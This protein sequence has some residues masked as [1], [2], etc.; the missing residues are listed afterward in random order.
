MNRLLYILAL[1]GSLLIIGVMQVR[2]TDLAQNFVVEV[3]MA[4]LALSVA[5]V[6]FNLSV[7][8]R[9][10][11]T[12]YIGLAFLAAGTFELMHALLSKGIFLTP[13]ATLENFHYVGDLLDNIILSFMLACGM[14]LAVKRPG[15]WATW[16]YYSVIAVVAAS[17][18]IVALSQAPLPEMVLISGEPRYWFAGL[19]PC[20]GY[21]VFVVA[22]V[23]SS[24]SARSLRERLLGYSLLPSVLVLTMSQVILMV[25][26]FSVQD[27]T[28]I[29]QALKIFAYVLA[30]IP[31]L[32]NLWRYAAYSFQ[33]AGARLA[34]LFGITLLVLSLLTMLQFNRHEQE[35]KNSEE[36][37]LVTLLQEQHRL[38]GIEYAIQRYLLFGDEQYLTRLEK[39]WNLQKDVIE[40]LRSNE[41]SAALERLSQRFVRLQALS[42]QILSISETDEI[43][44]KIYLAEQFMEVMQKLRQYLSDVVERESAQLSQYKQQ[45]IAV[46]HDRLVLELSFLLCAILLVVFASRR[47]NWNQVRPVINLNDVA[48]KITS[49]ERDVE[50][51]SDRKDEIGKLS[52]SLDAML[53]HL[54]SAVDELESRVEE[55]TK[56]LSRSEQQLRNIMDHVE[57]GIITANHRGI[58]QSVNPAACK[59]FGFDVEQLTG[60]PIYKLMPEDQR[61][62]HIK[63]IS[64]YSDPNNLKSMGIHRRN[65][66]GLRSDGSTFSLEIGVTEV[67]KDG[68]RT[69]IAVLRDITERLKAQNA[70]KESEQRLSRF[71]DA[72]LEGLLFHE[73]GKIVDVNNAALKLFNCHLSDIIDKDLEQFMPADQREVLQ[74][75]L[76]THSPELWESVIEC[77][78][79]SRLPVE[80]QTRDVSFDCK[81]TSITVVR[82]IT[83][84][85]TAQRVLNRH[86]QFTSRILDIVGSLVF[87]VDAQ[88]NIVRFNKACEQLTGYAYEDVKG[89]PIWEV[90]PD[91]RDGSDIRQLYCT[92][93]VKDFPNQRRFEWPTKNGEIR[94]IDWINSAFISEDGMVEYVIG[95]GVDVTDRL[96][97]E[98]VLANQLQTLERKVRERTRELDAMFTLSP[99]GFVMINENRQVIYANPAF[100]DMTGFGPDQIIGIA[101]QE[102]C[103]LLTG[104]CDISGEDMAI[105]DANYFRENSTLQLIRPTERVINCAVRDM[106]DERNSTNGLV[107]YIRDITHE[108]EVDQMKS[109][110]LST[111]AHEFRTPLSSILGFSELLLTSNV[112]EEKRASVTEI[113]YRQSV[114]L[115]SL[116]DELLDLARIDARAG[117]DFYIAVDT[118]EAL[119]KETVENTKS[120]ANEKHVL[121]VELPDKWPLVAFDYDKMRQVLGNVLGNAYKYS[122]DGG[123]VTCTT[124]IR[125]QG[126]Q[127]QFGIKIQ[128]QGIG[129]TP[130]EL[131]RVGERFYRADSSGA[132]PGTGLGVS[133]VKE[134]MEIHKGEV[135]I[136]SAKDRGTTVVLWLPVISDQVTARAV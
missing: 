122:P 17:I 115:K 22:L 61:E 35:I 124:V 130:E 80:I 111:A 102:F 132:I 28:A 31:A 55:R 45:K 90:M 3:V 77:A 118:P 19:L 8:P 13:A 30:L 40:T 69:F 42:Q 133:L 91:L 63:T 68:K 67:I 75:M 5:L 25:P 64:K 125:E 56:E 72:S 89:E 62:A 84:R 1:A 20:A 39:L 24:S 50:I 131:S 83:E 15:I 34:T 95:A 86:N 88:G 10:R 100:F 101:E 60:S 81:T 44:H 51:V 9:N 12:P 49:G 32:V 120:L 18:I 126:R 94:T 54:R 110:F 41:D 99:D 117:K 36:Q 71:F 16:H 59:I 85:K 123:Q 121:K 92:P 107:L 21:F 76:G 43:S 109:E 73:R 48:N 108:T 29:A 53:R 119:I 26:V 46:I 134:I 105:K 58:I 136:S 70:L 97:V 79:G 116:L 37:L 112:K 52:K 57:E 128:D 93:D 106:E 78:D 14:R 103:R 27:A 4:S 65:E 87:V 129:M 74:R 2:P 114:Y 38:N 33:V 104:L 66:T 6:A 11:L 82:D 96:L 127:V 7:Q 113:I 135:E 47:H 23:Q 98:K